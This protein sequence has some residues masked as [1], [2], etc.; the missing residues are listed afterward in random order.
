[1]TEFNFTYPMFYEQIEPRGRLVLDKACHA[2]WHYYML[3]DK[4][5]VKVGRGI[6]DQ[7]IVIEEGEYAP[8]WMDKRYHQI[9]KTVAMIYGLESPED[10][11]PYFPLVEAEARRLGYTVEFEIIK[12][13]GVGRKQ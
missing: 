2:C 11:L 6:D 3:A 1:M 8:D 10:F 7:I 5:R 13:F 9:A 4:N 12:P